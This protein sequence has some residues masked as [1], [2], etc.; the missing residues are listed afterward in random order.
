[1]DACRLWNHGSKSRFLE[2]LNKVSS[3]PMDFKAVRGV[4]TVIFSF[5]ENHHGTHT[6]S[7]DSFS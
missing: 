4:H 3:I 5:K 7:L 2:L 6:N 1:M